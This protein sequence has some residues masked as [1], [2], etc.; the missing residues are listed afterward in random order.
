MGKETEGRD[1]TVKWGEKLLEGVVCVYIYVCVCVWVWGR[2]GG[3]M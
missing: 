1:S 2:G 3:S